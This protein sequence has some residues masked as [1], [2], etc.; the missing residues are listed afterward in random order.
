MI[1]I[2][3]YADWCSACRKLEHTTFVNPK[4]INAMLGMQKIRVDLSELNEENLKIM[5]KMNIIG[6]PTI[7]FIKNN[8]ILK[9]HTITGFI[10]PNL[11]VD[12][13][14]SMTSQ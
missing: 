1:I 3:F 4:V 9:K 5:Q 7:L 12:H 14:N 2:D 10:S 13:I 11:M 8:T 6:L